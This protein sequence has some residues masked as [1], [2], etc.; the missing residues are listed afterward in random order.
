M[1]PQHLLTSVKCSPAALVPFMS[2]LKDLTQTVPAP[3]MSFSE[4]LTS[5]P[6][7]QWRLP[8]SHMFAL[9]YWGKSGIQCASLFCRPSGFLVHWSQCR[10]LWIIHSAADH[11]WGEPS[12]W[13]EYVCK[14]SA[15]GQSG[16]YTQ[17]ICFAIWTLGIF[18][19]PCS[20]ICEILYRVPWQL[21]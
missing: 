3:F 17:L 16:P 8:V 1:H 21:A 19:L 18:C 2:F 10:K 11:S 20:L 9:L 6:T 4:R 5:F 13:V 14:A 15:S 7:L 12:N